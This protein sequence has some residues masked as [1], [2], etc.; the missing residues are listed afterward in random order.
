MLGESIAPAAQAQPVLLA[1]ASPLSVGLPAAATQSRPAAKPAEVPKPPAVIAAV[2]PI[3]MLPVDPVRPHSIVPDLKLGSGAS[4]KVFGFVK[5]SMIHD[6]SSPSGTDMPLP[7]LNGDTGP[8]VDPEFHIRARNMRIGTQF[9]W[10]DASPKLSVTGRFEADFEGNF[11]RTLN[12]N[13]STVRSSQLSLRTAWGRI[14]RIIDDK[15]SVYTLMG[16]DWT[17]FGSSTL[18]NLLETTGLGLGYGTLY[19]RAPQARFGRSALVCRRA[20]REVHAGGGHGAAGLWEHAFKRGRPVGLRGTP[21][22]GQQPPGDAGPL[23]DAMAARPGRGRG[24]GA[25]HPQLGARQPDGAGTGDGRSG[26]V[27]IGLPERG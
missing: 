7:Y 14:D 15:W 25:V 4:L 6:T 22:G 27:Q 21:G 19:E 16:Q 10:P 9:E 5:A 13:I 8:T 18:P 26:S 20:P 1:S 24:S 23:R 2:A 11:T 12:R 3:R 17:P